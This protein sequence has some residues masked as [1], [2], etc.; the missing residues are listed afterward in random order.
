MQQSSAPKP[1]APDIANEDHNAETR[2]QA[3]PT[4]E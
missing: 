1:P 3:A 4:R 2:P